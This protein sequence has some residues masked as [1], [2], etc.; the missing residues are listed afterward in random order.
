MALNYERFLNNLPVLPATAAKVLTLAESKDFSFNTLEETV[1]LDPSLTSKILRIANSAQ[2]ARQHEVT[3]L[4]T[5]IT[6]LGLNTIKNLVILLTGSGLF[7]KSRNSSFYSFFWK[8]S[9]L[10]AFLSRDLAL[11]VGRKD[12]ADQAFVAGLLHNIGQ[13]AFYLA[14]PARY[15]ALLAASVREGRR[16]SLLEEEEFG[17]DHK[18]VGYQVLL[19]WNF[20]AVY[21]DAALEHGNNNITSEH[22]QLIVLVSVAD[23][24]ASNLDFLKDKPHPLTLLQPFL[25]FLGLNLAQL[26]EFQA[27]CLDKLTKDRLF[28][29]CKGIFSLE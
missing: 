20:P 21:T 23:F 22:K 28:Q 25:P 11:K 26:G 5:A 16:I 9:L 18:R 29:E 3:E 24:V 14:D 19:G 1:M 15:E 13:V 27:T 10:S 2:F 4:R 12:K 7:L 8:H 6:L 17:T